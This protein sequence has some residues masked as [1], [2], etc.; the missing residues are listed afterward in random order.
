MGEKA[1]LGP[2]VK[3]MRMGSAVLKPALG[4]Q[5][6][7]RSVLGLGQRRG[8]LLCLVGLQAEEVCALAAASEGSEEEGV[9]CH[10]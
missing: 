6:G 9:L 7:R 2:L 1:S 8:D 5:P 3:S 4:G 10:C